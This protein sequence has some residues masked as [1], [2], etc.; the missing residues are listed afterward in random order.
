MLVLDSWNSQ[1]SSFPSTIHSHVFFTTPSLF[2]FH[3][4]HLCYHEL[5][6]SLHLIFKMPV[7]WYMNNE[8]ILNKCF[9]DNTEKKSWDKT[10]FSPILISFYSLQQAIFE[11]LIGTWSFKWFTTAPYHKGQTLFGRIVSCFT[12]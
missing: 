10:I 2:T 4:C 9:L 8:W 11:R 5:C 6:L 12:F 7:W 3:L 1:S